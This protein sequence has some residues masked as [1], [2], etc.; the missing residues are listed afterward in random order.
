MNTFTGIETN[1]LNMICNISFVLQF[2][3]CSILNKHV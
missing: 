1:I 2:C 3:Y